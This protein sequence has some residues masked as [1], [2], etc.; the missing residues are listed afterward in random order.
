MPVPDQ[1]HPDAKQQQ[2]ANNENT[3]T[4]LSSLHWSSLRHQIASNLIL[5]VLDFSDRTSG[6]QP[7]FVEDCDAIRD[8][9]CPAHVVRDDDQSGV[10]LRFLPQQQFIDLS[11]RYPVQS[12]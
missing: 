7:S 5:A 2:P 9:L 12:A 8:P 1:K 4:C 3:D 10:M 11:S 6:D